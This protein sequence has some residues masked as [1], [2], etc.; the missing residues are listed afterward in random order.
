MSSTR[1]RIP[2]LGTFL[3]G[4]ATLLAGCGNEHVAQ[5]LDPSFNASPALVD[6]LATR[7]RDP[8]EGA[9]AKD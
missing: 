6:V 4:G 5:P 2:I 3:L 8:E 9:P 1:S 7:D